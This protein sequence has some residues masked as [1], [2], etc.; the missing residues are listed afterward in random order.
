ML[1]ITFGK[2]LL[3]SYVLAPGSSLNGLHPEALGE[4][5]ERRMRGTGDSLAV[6]TASEMAAFEKI[7]KDKE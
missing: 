5:D 2:G 1:W 7:R 3:I 4:T 6:A